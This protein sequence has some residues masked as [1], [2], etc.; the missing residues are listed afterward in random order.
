MGRIYAYSYYCIVWKSFYFLIPPKMLQK[1]TKSTQHAKNKLAYRI[2]F[3]TLTLQQHFC[4][5]Y[6]E[7][8]DLKWCYL[9]QKLKSITDPAFLFTAKCSR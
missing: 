2:K 5:L 9:K 7:T 3:S 4:K 1:Q 8:R 6:L